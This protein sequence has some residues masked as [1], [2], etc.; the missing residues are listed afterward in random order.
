M[1]GETVACRNAALAGRAAFLDLGPGNAAVRIYG[2]TRAA[3]SA[4]AP[5]SAMLVEIELTKPCGVVS[6]GLLVLTPLADGLIT[7]T[8]V[9]TWARFVNGNGDTAFDADAGEG[10]G[11]WEVQLVNTDLY[12][13]GSARIVSA[14]LG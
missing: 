6:G 4:D 7:T 8:G 3:S 9:G 10:V 13:G 11:G 12:A 14:V 1:I 5:G 2:A